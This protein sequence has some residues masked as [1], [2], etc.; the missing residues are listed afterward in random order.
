MIDEDAGG[1]QRAVAVSDAVIVEGKAAAFFTVSLSE[2]FTSNTALTFATV[3]GSA[4][5]GRDFVARAG[6]VAFAAGQT[7]AQVGVVLRDDRGVEGAET[8]GLKVRGAGVA[9]YGEAHIL[10][11]DAARPIA[12][13]ESS[14]AA[15]GRYE[16]F[17]VRLSEASKSEVTVGYEALSRSALAG[18]DFYATSGRL[19]F[20]AGETE[21]TVRVYAVNDNTSEPDEFFDFRLS[22]PVG[23]RFA[24]GDPLPTATGMILDDDPG[25]QKRVIAISDVRVSEAG[26]DADFRVDLSRALDDDLVIR[27]KAFNGTAKANDYDRGRGTLVIAAGETEA[28]ISIAVAN[29]RRVE[30]NETFGLKF[31]SFNH[32]EFAPAGSDVQATALIVNDDARGHAALALH[33]HD[34][35]L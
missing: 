20:A 5:A 32:R 33:D 17:A 22:N 4:H 2:A 13:V 10:D 30:G 23:A 11:D 29:D 24:P 18:N 35:L 25:F 1:G 16:T 27:F 7:E 9:G 15:E 14:I 21:K 3:A 26:G 8:F 28:T 6:Q 12:S 19:T 31:L 34:M